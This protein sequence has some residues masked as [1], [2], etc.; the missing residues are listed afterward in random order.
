MSNHSGISRIFQISRTT[1]SRYI[2]LRYILLVMFVVYPI[3]MTQAYRFF[4]ELPPQFFVAPTLIVIIIGILLTRSALLKIKLQE[5]SEQF[6]A[7]ADLAQEFT[8]LRSIDGQYEYVSPSCMDFTGYSQQEF[9]AIPHL[10]NQLIH[11]DDV[12]LWKKHVHHINDDGCAEA[13][14]L[15]LLTKAGATI[16]FNHICM[17]VYDD[18]GEQIGV[19]STNLDITKRKHDEKSIERMA[20][21]DALTNLPNRRSLQRHLEQLMNAN[22]RE[23]QDFPVL[24]LDLDRFKN[25][26]DSLG[27]HMGDRLLRLIARRIEEV[28]GNKALVCRFGGDEFVIVLD[29]ESLN[30]TVRSFAI[31]LLRIIE[32]PLEL[33][34]IELHVSASIGIAFYPRDGEDADTLIRNADVAMY[35][36]K[37]G[38]A[39]NIRI[40]E[41]E[42]S[43]EA[44]RFITTETKIHKGLQQ[45]E[46]TVY[47]QPKVDMVN[48]NII[49]MEAL[50]R[51]LHPTQGIIP[52]DEFIAIAEE[53]GQIIPLGQ[54][55]LNQVLTDLARWQQAGIALPVSVNVSARQFADMKYNSTVVEMIN[56]QGIAANLLELE[57][58]EQVF[59]GDIDTACERLTQ[60]HDAGFTIALDDFGTGFSSFGYLRQLPIDTLK[61]DRSFIC[62]IVTDAAEI[63]IIRAIAGMCNEMKLK[64]VVEGVET[65]EQSKALLSLGCDI[66]Q[67]YYYH[68][69]M[70]SS[71]LDHLLTLQIKN[72]NNLVN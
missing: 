52:P 58:T 30:E 2:Y 10:M 25:I 11:P 44:T 54:Q 61:I 57:V 6:R 16:W 72:K 19:R 29:H 65:L 59:L 64:V 56:R 27:H 8:Y 31:E 14:D 62:N 15:R 20:Y 48:G 4:D 38:G 49:G 28:S 22:I 12:G 26:N 70:P 41:E 33:D 55:L 13:F 45:H 40:Y 63:A 1:P 51:W 43:K 3:A 32:Q 9:Y 67:G 42:D 47:Y 60:L 68:R 39:D 50:A 71:E 5:K 66:A 34:G 69:P 17:P 36:T 7:I 53:T 35:K 18:T 21:F 24:F 23:S 37:K 46:F